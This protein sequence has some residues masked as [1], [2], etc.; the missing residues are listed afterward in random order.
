MTYNTS[1]ASKLLTL[2]DEDILVGSTRRGFAL[3]E[4]FVRTLSTDTLEAIAQS[5]GYSG[6]LIDWELERREGPAEEEDKGVARL[7]AQALAE[8]EALAAVPTPGEL[9]A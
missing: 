5:L 6:Q 7:C 9:A 2:L 8:M 4:E 1:L 3:S